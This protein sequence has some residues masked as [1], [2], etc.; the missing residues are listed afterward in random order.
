MERI[1]ERSLS[2][3]EFDRCWPWLEASLEF[4]A[5]RH[6][7]MMLPTH[8]KEHVWERIRTKRS[9][10]W[11][12]DDCA[13]VTEFYM[14]PTSIKSHHTWLAGGDLQ[15]IVAAMPAIEEWGRICECH[16]QTGSG[17]RGWLRAFEGYHEIGVR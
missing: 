8:H 1:M 10:F 11:P 2:A 3:E 16:Q 15:A 13:L 9:M 7:G 6:K 17:R 14:T 5:F 4:A 12:G